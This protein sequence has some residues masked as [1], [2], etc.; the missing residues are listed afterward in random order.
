MDGDRPRLPANRNCYG[1]SRVLMSISSDFLYFCQDEWLHPAV[2]KIVRNQTPVGESPHRFALLA[3][4]ALM[5]ISWH[6]RY[7]EIRQ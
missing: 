1:F 3:L 2:A 7:Q 6:P 5:N 4:R